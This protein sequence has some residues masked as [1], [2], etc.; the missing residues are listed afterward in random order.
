MTETSLHLSAMTAPEVKEHSHWLS[1]VPPERVRSW[2]RDTTD[3]DNAAPDFGAIPRDKTG[4]RAAAVLALYQSDI[5]NRPVEQCLEW[6]STEIG[7]NK[8][9]HR[10]AR[11]LAAEAEKD[12]AGLDRRLNRFSRGRTMADASPVVRNILRTAIVEM[13]AYPKTNA[14]VVVSEAVKLSQMFDTHKTGRFVNGVLGAVV[15]DAQGDN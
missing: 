8:K 10:F 14:A 13:D 15:R 9:L 1:A 12:R 5:T 7:L 3:T 2:A 6:V 11:S 4:G